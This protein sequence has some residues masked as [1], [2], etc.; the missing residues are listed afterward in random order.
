MLPASYFTDNWSYQNAKPCSV[1]VG[2]TAD[3]FSSSKATTL[4][5]TNKSVTRPHPSSTSASG[6]RELKSRPRR[7]V[8][9]HASSPSISSTDSS[10]VDMHELITLPSSTTVSL[11]HGVSEVSINQETEVTEGAF[12][13]YV[14]SSVSDNGSTG[15]ITSSNTTLNKM[16]GSTQTYNST[17]LSTGQKNKLNALTISTKPINTKKEDT[18]PLE[19]E[20]NTKN[21]IAYDPKDM[22]GDAFPSILSYG[23]QKLQYTKLLTRL[24]EVSE[25]LHIFSNE[26]SEP[27]RNLKQLHYDN[28]RDSSSETIMTTKFD[29]NKYQT[30]NLV[31]EVTAK[32]II[33]SVFTTHNAFSKNEHVVPITTLSPSVTNS[34][35]VVSTKTAAT[36]EKETTTNNELPFATESKT[37]ETVSNAK[38]VLINLT[39]SADDANND[40]YKP[41]YSLT[42]TV[43]TVGDS[44]EIPTV[45][46]TPLDTEPT[47]PTNFN[48]PISIQNTTKTTKTIETEDWGGSCECSCPVCDSGHSS[49]DLYD[50]YVDKTTLFNENTEDLSSPYS[51]DGST[52][53]EENIKTTNDASSEFTTQRELNYISTTD[54]VTDSD[55]ASK[56]IIPDIYLS[57]TDSTIASSTESELIS[58]TDFPKC[59][60]PKIKPPPILILEGEVSQICVLKIID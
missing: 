35:N 40:S 47:M 23:L 60:C 58:T 22:Q 29:F 26:Y 51:T 39:I 19:I 17:S 45:K 34:P 27:E 11:M 8:D 9:G 30:S 50:D 37:S 25:E 21:N 16:G 43:P 3:K 57:T 48:K 42:V 24:N 32:P 53:T 46:I 55:L 54:S 44:N 49:D 20:S 36:T 4:E 52:I 12:N 2:D 41:L 28:D 13:A 18:D 1:L 5:S 15:N 31:P 14:S 10:S 59:V 33:E 38:H 7:S 56:D 6:K